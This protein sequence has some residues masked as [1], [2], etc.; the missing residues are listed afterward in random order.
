MRW[1]FSSANLNK[2]FYF[3]AEI[4]ELFRAMRGM[5]ILVDILLRGQGQMFQAPWAT[6]SVPR[7]LDS[8]VAVQKL[9]QTTPKQ[10]G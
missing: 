7:L 1:F 6:R 8:D 5:S 4:S 2:I 9:P 3:T 10:M